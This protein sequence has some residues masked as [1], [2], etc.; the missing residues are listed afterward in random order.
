MRILG[1]ELL[2]ITAK[3]KI[4][5]SFVGT[6]HSNYC[7][8]NCLVFSRTFQNILKNIIEHF[9]VLKMARR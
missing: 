5:F 2:E 1:D 6:Y 8:E 3:K 9:R 4:T 7:Y